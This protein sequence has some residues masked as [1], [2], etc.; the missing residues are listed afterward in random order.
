MELT[1]FKAEHLLE[2]DILRTDDGTL[3]LDLDEMI[4]RGKE[5]EGDKAF[6]A[7]KHGVIIGCGGVKML[8]KGVGEGWVVPSVHVKDNKRDCIILCVD[9]I[10]KIFEDDPSLNR[11]QATV[12]QGFDAGDILAAY[13]GFSFEGVLRKYGLNGEDFK[14]FSIVR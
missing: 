4:R 3:D 7:C 1:A 6:T 10:K 13:A 12:V 14:M 9:T 11:I 5:R 2:M 8:W